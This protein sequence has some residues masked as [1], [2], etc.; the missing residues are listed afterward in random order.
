MR[1][2]SSRLSLGWLVLWVRACLVLAGGAWTLGLSAPWWL[3]AVFAGAGLLAATVD[4]VGPVSLPIVRQLMAA[5]LGRL[6][7]VRVPLALVGAVWLLNMVALPASG[8]AAV[9]AAVAVVAWMERVN[10]VRGEH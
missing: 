4:I 8:R 1:R 5:M 2:M 3:R 10:L 9:W 7:M 6:G